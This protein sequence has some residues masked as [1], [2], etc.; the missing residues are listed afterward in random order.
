MEI[1]L[2]AIGAFVKGRASSIGFL[3][4]VSLFLA[5]EFLEWLISIRLAVKGT[6]LAIWLLSE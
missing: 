2:R 4:T 1:L 6:F 3:R 5:I